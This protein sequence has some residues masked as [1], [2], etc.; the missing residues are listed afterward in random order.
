MNRLNQKSSVGVFLKKE[1][2]VGLGVGAGAGLDIH[3][4]SK[5]CTYQLWL[6][7]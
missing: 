6:T 7:T 3:T 1:I 4:S 2:G 5:T